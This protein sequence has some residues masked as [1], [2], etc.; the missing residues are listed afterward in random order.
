LCGRVGCSGCRQDH[1]DARASETF[2]VHHGSVKR[3][4]LGQIK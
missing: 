3:N 4:S 2:K 1:I